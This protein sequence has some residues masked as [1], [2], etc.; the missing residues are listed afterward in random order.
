MLWL[1]S[2]KKFELTVFEETF[3]ETEYLTA[4]AH[5]SLLTYGPYLPSKL[6]FAI[7]SGAPTSASAAQ[8]RGKRS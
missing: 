7:A 4:R 3:K 5:L 2:S 8:V 1:K 6:V